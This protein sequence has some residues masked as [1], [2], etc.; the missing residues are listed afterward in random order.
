MEVKELVYFSASWCLRETSVSCN[1]LTS[2]INLLRSS[3]PS[4]H[5]RKHAR[6]VNNSFSTQQIS[7]PSREG[8]HQQA[9]GKAISLKCKNSC[10]QW[11]CGWKQEDWAPHVKTSTTDPKH[12]G[13]GEQT[14][15]SG[16]PLLKW[17]LIFEEKTSRSFFTTWGISQAGEQEH[18]SVF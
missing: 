8:K 18:D 4:T 12:K 2:D 9:E 17:D 14:T 15:Q 13:R 11:G 7:A 5:S 3:P 6:F 16:I 10:S 1:E